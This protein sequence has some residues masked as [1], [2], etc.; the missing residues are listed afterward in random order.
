MAS[1]DA[2]AKADLREVYRLLAEGKPVTDAGLVRR[3][4]ES[5]RCSAPRRLRA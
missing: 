2:S 4:R 3:I 5:L 1:D